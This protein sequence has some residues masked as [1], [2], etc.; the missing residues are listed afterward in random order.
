MQS[1]MNAVSNAEE[2]DKDGDG[3]FDHGEWSS[4]SRESVILRRERLNL[5]VN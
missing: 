3:C 5:G 2:R 1:M 4:S